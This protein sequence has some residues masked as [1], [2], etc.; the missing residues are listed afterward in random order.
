[1]CLSS[2]LGV[3]QKWF[4]TWSDVA[5]QGTMATQGNV[6]G[7]HNFGGSATGKSSG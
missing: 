5:T 2:D 4:P 6:F 3:L 7:F 1:M